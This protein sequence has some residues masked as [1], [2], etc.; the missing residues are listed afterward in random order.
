MVVFALS[1]TLG[2][3]WLQQQPT[4]PDFAWAWL[5]L[6]LPP[7]L[8]LPRR[9]HWQRL[10]RTI[11][12]ALLGCTLGFY[13]AAWQAELRL[14][15]SLPDVWQGRDINV[16]GVVAELPRSHERGQRF[17]FDVEQV[18]TPEAHV[19]AH[20]YLA[21][22]TDAK[23][24]P[25]LLRAGE[26]WRFTIRLKQ[27]HG[28][29][30]PGGFDFEGWMLERDLRA[31]GYVHPKG[32]NARLDA[33]AEGLGYRIETW[34]EAVR[35]KFSATLGGAP[36]AGIL[37]ALAIGDQ[38]SIPPPQWQV[39]TRTGVNHLMSISGLHITMLS[40]LAFTLAYWLWRRSTRLTL[41]LPA[42]KAAALAALFIAIGYALL[43]GFGVPA[44]RTVY[45]V[46]AGASTY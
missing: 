25:L 33:L 14:S 44:Q 19:P 28:T 7:A 21:T 23:S 5:L 42:R 31:T 6:I 30:N 8:L 17:R 32:D 37:S 9:T 12:I 2:V 38:D 16:I 34:R 22:Y 1:F 13:H 35:D 41:W 39:F 45:M 11:L 3:W 20:V 36:Y 46:G 15:D 24:P 29:A 26:R 27:P 43:A 18:R 40:G 4:L 10:F